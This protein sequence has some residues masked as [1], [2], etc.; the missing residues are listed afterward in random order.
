[1]ISERYNL[2]ETG[3]YNYPLAF[4][5][6]PNIVSYLH[7]EG[8]EKRPCMLIVPGGGY[9][10]VSASEGEI[11]ALEFYKKGFNVFVC[12]Y[13][14]D[15]VG[16]APLKDQPMKDL[17]RA[18][19]Y[20]RAHSE[21]F[22]I[23]KEQL[24]VC[25]FSA[26][27]HLCGSVC[28]HAEDIEDE[29]PKYTE[30]SNKPNAA[31]LSYPVITTGEKAHCGSFEALFGTEVTEEDLAYMSLE[32]HVKRD[33]PP[34]FLWQ[35]VTDETVPVE[36][37]YLFAM[38]C[39]KQGVHYAHHVFSKGRHGLSLANEAWVTGEKGDPYTMEQIFCTAKAV[40][41][42][43]LILSEEAAERLEEQLNRVQKSGEKWLWKKQE[44]TVE[45]LAEVAVWPLLAEEWL[46]TVL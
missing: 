43:S 21:E 23:E 6:I 41:D 42:G 35:T 33:T 4:G 10:F 26:G 40:E 36:N 7:E 28:V 8:E 1:M 39:K 9:R 15:I 18:I 29:N 44:E 45:S 32:K 34:C 27:G 24:V 25:G 20:I 12:T 22:H 19:R 3:E 30:I 31:I 38:A 16:K 14:T 13:T 5:F 11:V 17:S 46:K 2:W 37:S